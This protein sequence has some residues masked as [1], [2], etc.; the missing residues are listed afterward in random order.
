MSIGSE[1]GVT[2]S[3]YGVDMTVVSVRFSRDP[4]HRRLERAASLRGTSISTLAERLIDEG[5]RMESHPLI[6]FRDGPAGRRPVL[7][8]RLEVAD[9]IGSIV[10]GDVDTGDRRQR[11]AEMLDLTMPQVDAALAYYAEF[12]DEIDAELS[13]RAAIAAAEEALWLRQQ[14]LLTQ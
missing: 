6:A 1:L 2:T 14:H 12:T 9:V 8:G 10:G 11:A 7:M 5:L 4:V 3:N 13:A